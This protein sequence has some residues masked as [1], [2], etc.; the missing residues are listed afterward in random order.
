MLCYVHIIWNFLSHEL[1]ALSQTT[2]CSTQSGHI[3]GFVVIDWFVVICLVKST[4]L[5]DLHCI[6][7]CIQNR[8]RITTRNIWQRSRKMLST[9]RLA[10]QYSL[11]LWCSAGSC[12]LQC[13]HIPVPNPIFMPLFSIPRASRIPL[14]KLERQYH[15][16]CY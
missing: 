6:S 2:F 4:S 11:C 15:N 10:L 16:L 12:M 14:H 9:P 13:F 3:Q 1:L 5:G 7:Q 8:G